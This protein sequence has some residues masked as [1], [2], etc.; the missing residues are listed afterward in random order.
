MAEP[1]LLA[2]AILDA[3]EEPALIVRDQRTLAANRAARPCLARRSSGA[4]CAS[5][6]AIRWR[7]T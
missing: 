6:S 1:L 5:P 7:S 2:A 3:I 4:T